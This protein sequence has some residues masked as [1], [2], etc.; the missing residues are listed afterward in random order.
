[1][2][3]LTKKR[4]G[5]AKVEKNGGQKTREGQLV[6]PGKIY[7]PLAAADKRSPRLLVTQ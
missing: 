2:K 7:L 6:M 5:K 3:Q 1:M 4:T